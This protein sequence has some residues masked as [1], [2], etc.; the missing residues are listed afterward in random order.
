MAR[1]KTFTIRF[2]EKEWERLHRE[3]ERREVPAAQLIRDW[4]KTLDKEAEPAEV[5]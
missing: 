3:A 2:N 1:E 4:L 5:R